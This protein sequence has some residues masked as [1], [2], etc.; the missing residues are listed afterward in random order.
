MLTA[1]HGSCGFSRACATWALAARDFTSQQ[2]P[3]PKG[4]WLVSSFGRVCNTRGEISHGT[5]HPSGYRVIAI[6]GKNWKV[7]RVVKVTF[8]GLPKSPQAWQVHHVDSDKANNRLDNLEYVTASQNVYHSY[9]SASRRNNKLALSQPVLWRLVG[10]TSWTASSSITAA[11]QQLGMSRQTVST[12]SRN[13]SAAKGYEFKLQDAS[14]HRLPGEEWR[15][16]LDPNS[17]AKV[18]GRMVSSLGRVT[19]QT[20]LRSYGCLSPEGYY[21]TGLR[22]SR[23]RTV[24]GV[25]RLVAFAYLGPPP[26]PNQKLVNHR[27]LDKGNNSVRN[28][29]WVSPAENVID[30]YSKSVAETRTS[31]KPVWSRPH[32]ADDRWTRHDSMARAAH[33]LGVGRRDISRCIRRSLQQVDGFEFRL[34]KLSETCSLPGE[35]WRQVNVTALL[36]DKE[37]R[38]HGAK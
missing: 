12:R 24:I 19:S 36:Q 17:G 31:A 11:S 16:M 27:D 5:F 26:T 21:V 28:L 35:V 13:Q 18:P 25:H 22:I 23:V 29:E 33:E 6:S 9:S 15:P 8:H 38:K 10:S 37:A 2:L 30:F 1:W 20:G 3:S 14:Q 7:H 4:G 32:G 34:D